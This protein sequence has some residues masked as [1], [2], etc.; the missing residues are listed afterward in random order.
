[1]APME[2]KISIHLQISIDIVPFASNY[3]LLCRRPCLCLNRLSGFFLE[4]PLA[5][6]AIDHAH[7]R[8]FAIDLLPLQWNLMRLL[9]RG[10]KSWHGETFIEIRAEVVHPADREKNIQAELKN[11]KVTTL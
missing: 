7:A 6:D 1:M 5:P 10:P 3:Y 8:Q 2:N 9:C 11:L 4:S